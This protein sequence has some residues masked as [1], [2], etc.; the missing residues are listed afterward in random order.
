MSYNSFN[1][2]LNRF[3]AVLRKDKI[4]D[5]MPWNSEEKHQQQKRRQK[6]QINKQTNQPTNK[7][8]PK[9][10]TEQIQWNLNARK[11]HRT[12]KQ[13]R[14]SSANKDLKIDEGDSNE[15]VNKAIG[16]MNKRTPLHVQHTF[17][18][19]FLWRH[20]TNKEWKCLISRFY[21]G[22]KQATT[23]FSFSFR[24]WMW[25]LGIQL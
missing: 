15:N 23:K 11:S 3:T 17:F 19:R 21:R 18:R 2:L 4:E 12:G 1:A 8:K 9:K 5:N 6:Q 13:G 16:L 7:K 20:C 25:F 10:E 22:R 24:A 14:S